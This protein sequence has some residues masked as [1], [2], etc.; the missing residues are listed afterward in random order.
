MKS[1]FFKNNFS[2]FLNSKL[3]KAILFLLLIM[4]YL[5]VSNCKGADVISSIS[6]VLDIAYLWHC[7]FCLY[8][9]LYVPFYPT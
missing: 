3:F 6:L 2:D 5:T 4:S 7:V 9:C 8:F 1:S